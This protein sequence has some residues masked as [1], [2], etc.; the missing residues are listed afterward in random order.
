VKL[1]TQQLF[2]LAGSVVLLGAIFL[3]QAGETIGSGIE[4]GAA[5]G[6]ALLGG[7]LAIAAIVFVL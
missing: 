1:T 2:I 7:G 5:I 3:S 4:W 6:L